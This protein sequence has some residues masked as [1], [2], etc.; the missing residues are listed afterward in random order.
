MTE[1]TLL[2]VPA[3]ASIFGFAPSEARLT[4]RPRSVRWRAARAG[5]L[6]GGC[7]VVAPVVA[8]LPPHVAWALGAVVTGGVLGFRKWNERFTLEG[9]RG[10]CPKCEAVLQLTSKTRLTRTSTLPCSGCHHNLQLQVEDG[11]LGSI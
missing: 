9:I 1:Q 7:V 10:T 8:I 5:M 4:V 6:T 3:T 11:A 2:E